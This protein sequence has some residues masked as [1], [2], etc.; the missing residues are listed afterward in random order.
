MKHP[1]LLPMSCFARLQVCYAYYVNRFACRRSLQ[2]FLH[3]P[4][5]LVKLQQNN[6]EKFKNNHT[7]QPQNQWLLPRVITQRMK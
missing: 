1:H 6:A 3:P 2:S 7:Q 4:K 5:S